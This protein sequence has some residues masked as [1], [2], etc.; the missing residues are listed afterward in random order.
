MLPFLRIERFW[1]YGGV[2]AGLVLL[3]LV[4][5]VSDVWPAPLLAVYLGLPI[6]MIHQF[7]EHDDNRFAK[8]V[9]AHIGKGKEVLSLSAIFWINIVLV[10]AWMVFV[11]YLTRYVAVGLGILAVLPVFLNALIHIGQAVRMRLY[12]PGLV[13]GIILLLPWSLWAGYV[14]VS[15][16]E[17]SGLDYL[18]GTLAAVVIHGIILVYAF[19]RLRM[20]KSA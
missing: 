7:E 1:V 15:T 18:W 10:W 13:T 19:W 3:A 6:Y 14:L 9:N 20:G 12:N 2:V 5:L 16:G 17:V 11:L 4:P 8:F